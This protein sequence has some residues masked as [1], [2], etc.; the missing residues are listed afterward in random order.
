VLL[1]IAGCF[2][3]AGGLSAVIWTDLVQAVIMI[4][5]AFVVMAKS[6][7]NIWIKVIFE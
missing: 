2:T 1:L 7:K 6:N 3:V 4:I 5:G